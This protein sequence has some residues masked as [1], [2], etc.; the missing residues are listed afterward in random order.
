MWGY[1]GKILLLFLASLFIIQ[2]YYIKHYHI[3]NFDWYS[4]YI[5]IMAIVYWIYKYFQLLHKPEDQSW[6]TLSISLLRVTSFAG[7][8]LLI[9]SCLYFIYKDLNFL[10]GI[11]LFLKILGLLILPVIFSLISISVWKKI[12]SHINGFIKENET[13][14]NIMS[15]VFGFFIVLTTIIIVW[16]LWLYTLYNV[17]LILIW[18]LIFSW[19]T[20]SEYINYF[21]QYKFNLSKTEWYWFKLL[22]TEFL[23]ILSTLLLSIN[24]ISAFR[25]FPIGWDDLGAY[26]NYAQLLAESGTIFNVTGMFSWES[27]TWIGYL[28]WSPTQAFILNNLW[29][30]LSFILLI[31]I[32]SD[33]LKSTTKKFFINIPLLL[34]TIF[35][36]MPMFIFEQAKDMK[37]D[38]GLFFVSISCIYLTLK[39]LIDWDKISFKNKILSIFGNTKS[40]IG[41]KYIYFIIIWIL[42][43][44]AFSIKFTSLLLISGLIALIFYARLWTIALFGYIS[45]YF[46]I[47]T[48]FGLWK[49]MN[50]SYP[51]ND[52]TFINT[53]S[54]VSGLIWIWMI[55]YAFIINKQ[56]I[57]S[58]TIKLGSFLLGI[59]IAL[60]PWFIFNISTAENISISSFLSGKSERLQID[61]SKIYNENELELKKEIQSSFKLT[62]SG[63]TSNEDFGRYFGYEEGINNYVKLPWNLTM[64][65][66]QRWEFTDITYIYLALL[67]LILLFLPFKNRYYSLWIVTLF[68]IMVLLFII[69]SSSIY[70]TSIL[71]EY[72]LPGWY[73]LLFWGFIIPLLYLLYT[74]KDTWKGILF[75]YILIF[76][77][78]YTFLWTI[79]A[80]G[81]VWYGIAMYFAFLLIIWIGL[82]YISWYT[83]TSDD[84][85]KQIR[86]LWTLVTWIIIFIYFFASSI[87]HAF[88]NLKSEAYQEFKWGIVHS[89]EAPYLY[90]RDYL[91]IL[92]ELNIESAKKEDFIN[93]NLE[94]SVKTLIIWINKQPNSQQNINIYNIENLVWYLRS[95]RS[96]ANFSN[97]FNDISRS[98]NNIYEWISHPTEEFK[99]TK[100]IYRIWTFLK[101]YISENHKRLFEDSLVTKFDTYIRWDTVDQ[102]IDNMKKLWLK[103]FLIDLNAATIDNDPRKN[104]TQRY[105]GLLETFISD[106]LEFISSDSICLRLWREI[107][108]R[109][110]KTEEDYK[111]YLLLA[112]INYT[113]YNNDWTT[114]NN[115]DKQYSCYNKIL[116]FIQEW[117]V[118]NTDYAYLLPIQNY[119]LNNPDILNNPDAVL[120]TFSRLIPYWYKVLFK[121]KD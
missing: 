56:R 12:L 63:T 98:L 52:I 79:A 70:L 42:T 17:V 71:S 106:K 113:T 36:A 29:G 97:Y 33:L 38:P 115:I 111:N 68:L 46:A 11:T 84:K 82:Y 117:K 50:V 61:Y 44:F 109:W 20:F 39:I 48:K 37:L 112:G 22:S 5:I 59:L 107:Y 24:L 94:E 27:F 40:H 23:F 30:L 105:E 51:S 92:Y 101:Y 58:F 7:L 91:K 76:T 6:D 35:I 108:L 66:N 60:F 4:L 103:Y 77:F 28:F 95:M 13:F 47:F 34:A 18:Y 53:F 69:P 102:S 49:L 67:P 85:E 10:S 89:A 57:K 25:P 64:Q 99:N 55:I 86:F 73:G 80:Y 110:D 81:I 8:H 114:I 96:N 54:L 100:N 2:Q 118:N 87:P 41:S 45:L 1:L 21:I 43:W 9:L 74:V 15:L 120:N 3:E 32:F 104:L 88:I 90:H 19:K 14:K 75:K 121:I 31:S 83:D 93:K 78:F 16:M 72:K 26:M 116:S 119:L 65:T 62:S